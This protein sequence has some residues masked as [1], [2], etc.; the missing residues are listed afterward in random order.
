VL[1]NAAVAIFQRPI[2][3]AVRIECNLAVERCLP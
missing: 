1:T 2:Q 3:I